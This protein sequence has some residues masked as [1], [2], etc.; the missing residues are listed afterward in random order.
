VDH[1][2]SWLLAKVECGPSDAD[3]DTPI[4]PL[5]DGLSETA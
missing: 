3:M 1:V 4:L 2:E 5:V